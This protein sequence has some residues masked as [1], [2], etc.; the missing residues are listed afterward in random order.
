[1]E[2]LKDIKIL[3]DLVARKL[4]TLERVF[5]FQLLSYCISSYRLTRFRQVLS[6]RHHLF[7]YPIE[8]SRL[9]NMLLSLSEMIQTMFFILKTKYDI[10]I[11]I[12]SHW[13]NVPIHSI[14]PSLFETCNC[15]V[16]CLQ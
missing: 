9:K 7:G 1:M 5:H 16:L 15:R 12:L 10:F 3:R 4:E 6:C 11:F 8:C 2:F 14:S 13:T